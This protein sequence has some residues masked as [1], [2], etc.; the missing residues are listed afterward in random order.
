MALTRSQVE[1]IASLARLE[2][3]EDE[4]PA[5]VGNLSRIIDFVDQLENASTDHVEPMAHPL[6]MSQPL[7]ADEVTE[8][9]RRDR[10]Q[11]NAS[12]VEAGL[13][14]VPKVIE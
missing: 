3:T 2:I 6:N 8:K 14:L 9:D 13:Y 4:I 1:N 10:F 7:R 11:E 12:R 5:Y